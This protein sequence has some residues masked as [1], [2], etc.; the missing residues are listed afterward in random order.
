MADDIKNEKVVALKYDKN[1]K[2][3]KVIAKGSGYV[4]EK[5]LDIAARNNIEIH[6]DKMLAENLNKLDLGD[7]IPAE[8]F[9]I[10]AK[11]YAFIDKIDVIV[12]EAK[13]K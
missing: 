13:E 12:G 7:D 1:Y 4:A 9:E 10:V 2:A 6:T 11:I 3:P 8:M 5:I